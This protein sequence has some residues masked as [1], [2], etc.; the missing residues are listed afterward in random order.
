MEAGSAACPT[1]RPAPDHGGGHAPRAIN[2]AMKIVAELV[3][4]YESAIV[5]GACAKNRAACRA[6]NAV[7]GWFVC[8]GKKS[9]VRR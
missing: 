5:R 6:F 3:R 7:R 4:L 8:G 1:C 9:G 2:Y